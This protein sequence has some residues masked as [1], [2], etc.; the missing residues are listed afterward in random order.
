[1]NAGKAIRA[2]TK[3]VREERRIH[4]ELLKDASADVRKLARKHWK[5]TYDIHREFLKDLKRA[6]KTSKS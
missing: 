1:M 4:H 6:W 3:H 5:D 2:L